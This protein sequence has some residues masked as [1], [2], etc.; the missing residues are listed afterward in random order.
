[1]RWNDERRGGWRRRPLEQGGVAD[2]GGEGALLDGQMLPP[3]GVAVD[4]ARSDG[5]THLLGLDE[6]GHTLAEIVI[7]R[8]GR[9]ENEPADVEGQTPGADVLQLGRQGERVAIVTHKSLIGH[10]PHRLVGERHMV[11]HL[12]DYALILPPEIGLMGVKAGYLKNGLPRISIHDFPAGAYHGD[13]FS[14]QEDGGEPGTIFEETALRTNVRFG[15]PR[16]EHHSLQP[17]A[18]RWYPIV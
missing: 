16:L 15:K 5:H 8:R 9:L 6:M 18:V 1:M 7:G 12:I 2:G 3:L 17:R 14:G 11:G 13:V 10:A 4:I